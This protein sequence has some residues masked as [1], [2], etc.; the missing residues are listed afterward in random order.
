MVLQVLCK[1]NVDTQND[2]LEKVFL[3]Q[4]RGYLAAAT[5]VGGSSQLKNICQIGSFPQMI[6]K[7]KNIRNHYPVWVCM[8][9]FKMCIKAIHILF[10]EE[11]CTFVAFIDY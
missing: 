11:H 4:T 8:F 7:I 3:F 9:E 1:L 2:G 5:V 10:L 6:M